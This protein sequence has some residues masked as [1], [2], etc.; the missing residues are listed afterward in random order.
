MVSK[1]TIIKY[2]INVK[3]NDCCGQLKK[4]YILKAEVSWWFL[5]YT[6]VKDYF[7]IDIA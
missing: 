2:N 4:T 3:H 7:T 5:Q 1:V 6:K